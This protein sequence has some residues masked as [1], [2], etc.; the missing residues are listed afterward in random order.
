V[1]LLT[2][3]GAEVAV[4]GVGMVDMAVIKNVLLLQMFIGKNLKKKRTEF[5]HK[6]PSRGSRGTVFFVCLNEGAVPI[7]HTE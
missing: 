7:T 3:G 2:L 5:P 4:A 6:T 1:R